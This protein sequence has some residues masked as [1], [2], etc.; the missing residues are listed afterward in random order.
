MPLT[1]PADRFW[2]RL[3]QEPA[4]TGF[5]LIG[6]SALALHFGHRTSEDLDF[7]FRGTEE[8]LPI[9]LPRA[10]L[11]TVVSRLESAGASVLAN[12]SPAGWLEFERQGMDLHDY[13][14]SYV[15]DGVN[16]SFFVPDAPLAKLMRP[17]VVG[18]PR[19]AEE[20]ELFQ[21]KALV[22]ASRSKTRDWFDLYYLMTERGHTMEEFM[23]TFERVP[24]G[25]R[26][27]SGSRCTTPCAMRCGSGAAKKPPRA[28]VL[29]AQSVRCA[30]HR[31]SRGY[32]A[33]KKVLGRKRHLVVDTL[34]LILGVLVTPA[35][36][37]DPAGAALLLPEVVGRFGWLRHLWV[38]DTYAS[39]KVM[40]Q[41]R[42]WHPRRGLRVEVVRAKAGTKGFAVQPRRWVIERTF[43]W[44]TSNRRLV[45]DYETRE[46]SS[47]AMIFIAASK[48]MLKR[49]AKRT[50]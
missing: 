7:I 43:A 13:Q 4:L 33:G 3:Q 5:I 14:Q 26:T 15:V 49:L 20:D 39:L 17:G 44:L 1:P 27:A 48:L 34:G 40:D 30:N 36:V 9:Q 38:D 42:A 22:S 41:L 24:A 35:S 47:E 6:G 32:D 12:D 21:S 10:A 37:S 19:L 46:A 31:A 25:A 18:G 28:A 50:F 29:D 2:E 16:L 23:Q 11:K 8:P 45:R